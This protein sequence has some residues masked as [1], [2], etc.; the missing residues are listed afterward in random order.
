MEKRQAERKVKKAA[1]LEVDK[2]DYTGSV[3][4]KD[5]T[6]SALRCVEDFHFLLQ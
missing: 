4:P 2:L 5:M 1:K 3:W 6:S